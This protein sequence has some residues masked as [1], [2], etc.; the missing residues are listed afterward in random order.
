VGYIG[1]WPTQK[2][3]GRI[4]G[5]QPLNLNFWMPDRRY[6]EVGDL[7]IA[8][9]RPKERGRGEPPPG[10]SVVRVNDLRLLKSDKLGTR[11]PEQQFQNLTSLAGLS[12]YSFKEEE[13]GLVQ[14]WQ[15]N[16]PYPQPDPFFRYRHV[17]G[18][19]PQINLRCTLPRLEKGPSGM[20]I[21]YVYI[22]PDELSFQIW[23]SVSN[24]MHWRE[25]VSATRDL[26]NNWK[27]Q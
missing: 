20:C 1:P 25:Y 2:E 3:R 6:V 23:F 14:Y 11:S 24:L 7:S 17:E 5:R 16:W 8:G 21:G 19:D 4:S 9:F 12:S 13:F 18:S 26:F 27:T 10:A 22:T 15:H